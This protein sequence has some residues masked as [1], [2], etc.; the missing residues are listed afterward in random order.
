MGGRENGQNMP[1]SVSRSA[2][3]VYRVTGRGLAED[4]RLLRELLENVGFS[5]SI[6]ALPAQ[7]NR[8]LKLKYR[9]D[10]IAARLPALALGVAK[11]FCLI[12][13]L[14]ISVPYDLSIHLQALAITEIGKARKTWLVPNQEWFRSAWSIY[15]PL[16]DA[17]K[18]KTFEAE[19][20][21]VR[22]HPNVEYLGF[23]GC[24]VN[25]V[26][27]LQRPEKTSETFFLHVAGRNRRK[28]TERVAE[29][30]KRHPDWPSLR[31]VTDY[32]ETLGV[33][34]ENIEIFSRVHGDLLSSWQE[35][36]IAVVAPSRVEGF[37][38]SI[39][40]PLVRGGLVITTDAP[41]MNEL[42]DNRRGILVTAVKSERVWQGQSYTVVPEA[43]EEAIS[44]VIAMAPE[45]R[46]SMRAQARHWAL[47]NH[48][49]FV[50]NW[51]S[52][53]NAVWGEIRK[54]S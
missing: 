12:N 1:A 28:G 6:R 14:R 54:K 23:S 13:R 33:I 51:T 9:L 19:R 40:E 26:K 25:D 46:T 20:I 21:F 42:V 36:A 4:A 15:L 41:P 24:Y 47:A 29:V 31:L 32:P 8:R 5:V 18:C 35:E 17:V 43:L 7:S 37:G 11:L 38:H 16:Y 3:I 49:R 45:E 27:A 39:L 30:W 2:E 53:I 52:A 48:Q 50:E 34:P 10:A 44:R 22:L